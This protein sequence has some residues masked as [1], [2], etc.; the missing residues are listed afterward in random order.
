MKNATELYNQSLKYLGIGGH[1]CDESMSFA[2]N[3][4][5]ATLGHRDAILAMGWFYLNGRGVDKNIAEAQ[6]WYRKSARI[7][8]PHAMFSLGQIS[9]DSLA[10][11]DARRWFM[12]A[13]KHGHVRSLYWLGKMLKRGQGSPPNR[14]EAF[15]LFHRAAQ[16]NDPEAIRV[17]RFLSR[18]HKNT[19][20]IA[21]ARPGS[22]P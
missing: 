22:A 7:G 10:F 2:L 20:Q 15:A 19:E 14:S 1:P 8:D 18:R 17:L 13:S 6:R 4:E 12:R 11:T 3:Q 21:A 16:E 9:Y 5:A